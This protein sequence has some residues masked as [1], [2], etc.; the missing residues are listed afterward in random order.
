[1]LSTDDYLQRVNRAIDHV[2]ARLGEPLRLDEL[3]AVACFSPCHFHR[4]FRSLV[5][6]TV[7]EFVTRLRLE[8][9]LRMLTYQPKAGMTQVALACGFGS[10]SNFSRVFK[11][12]YGERESESDYTSNLFRGA[13]SAGKLISREDYW[14]D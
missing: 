8:R 5:G 2:I 12:R 7:A 13:M 1:M 6:E 11:R 4:I 14:R 10:S 3:A 9:A